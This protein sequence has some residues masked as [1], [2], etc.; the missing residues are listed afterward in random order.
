MAQILS[1][2]CDNASN[3]DTMIEALKD[4]LKIFPGES[5]R[6]RCFDPIVNLV[7]KSIIQQ[8]D[9]PKAT[10][11]ESFD[12]VL[13]ELMVSAKDL[14]KEELATREGEHSESKGDEDDTDGWVD[15][16]EEMSESERKELDDNIQPICRVLVKVSVMFVAKSTL[17][18][19]ACSSA[20][21]HTRSRTPQL[22][23]FPAGTPC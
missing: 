9:V 17:N 10:G 7:A 23:S 5:H 4:R 22:S 18:N 6:T 20:R 14:D 21:P 13:R 12:D 19:P 16:Q 15:E 3:N 11:N 8:V 2:T 1:V